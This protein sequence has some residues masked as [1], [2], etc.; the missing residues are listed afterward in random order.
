MNGQQASIRMI[1]ERYFPDE[2]GDATLATTTSSTTSGSS[3]TSSTFTTFVSGLPEFDDPEE[4]GITLVVTPEVDADRRTI[5]L[6]LN[7][8]ISQHTGWTDYS[9]EVTDNVGDTTQTYTQTLKKAEIS[10]RIVST[11]VSVLDGETIVLGGIISDVLTERYDKVP[12]LGELPLVGRL[13]QSRGMQ[14]TKTN[15]LIFLTCRLIKP[16]GSLLNPDTVVRGKP[17]FFGRR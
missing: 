16:D 13:F 4:E 8:R 9:Y 3:T 1:T 14:A 11:K 6:T 7:P 5:S 15:L 17:D 12:V 10:E 2:W